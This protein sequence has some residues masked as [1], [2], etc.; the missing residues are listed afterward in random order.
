MPPLRTTGG[1]G[2]HLVVPLSPAQGWEAVR[3]FAH[4]IARAHARDDP[5]HVTALL[6]KSK[7]EGRVFI[8]YLRNR[9]G[10]TA[11]ASYSTRARPGAPVAIPV[12]WDELGPDLRGDRFDVESTRQRL[13]SLGSDPWEGFDEARRPLTGAM[14][15]AVGERR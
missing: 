2:L 14:V 1:K 6:S 10:A 9:R 15:R 13:A 11:I 3:A 12:R 8:D 5:A 4:G 7:R